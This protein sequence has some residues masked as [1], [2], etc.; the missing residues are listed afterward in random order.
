M[1]LL[2]GKQW[3]SD[4]MSYTRLQKGFQ[5]LPSKVSPDISSN[6]F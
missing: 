3:M 5:R 1:T 2:E 4:Y 6:I